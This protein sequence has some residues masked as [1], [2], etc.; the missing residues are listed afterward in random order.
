[1]NLMHL[2]HRSIRQG[3]EGTTHTQGYAKLGTLTS[4]LFFHSCIKKQKVKN[5]IPSL[6]NAHKASSKE[7]TP[8]RFHKQTVSTGERA[9]HV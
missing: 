6:G 8:F 1:M 4:L 7:E 3:V 5:P 2:T 9:P